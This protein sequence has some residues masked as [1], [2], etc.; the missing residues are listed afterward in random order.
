MKSLKVIDFR[1]IATGTVVTR[2]SHW[3]REHC[4]KSRKREI[5]ILTEVKFFQDKVSGV[6][7]YPVIHWEGAAMSS[8]THPMNVALYRKPRVAPT[9]IEIS[10][11]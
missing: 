2:S 11:E 10:E 7:A 4:V 3:N 6:V 1:Q 5:G 8:M 9:M